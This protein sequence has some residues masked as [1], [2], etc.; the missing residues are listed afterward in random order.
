[1]RRIIT[2]IFVAG[3]IASGISY[4]S[5][6]P[7]ATATTEPAAIVATTQPAPAQPVA[8]GAPICDGSIIDTDCA[9]VEG[10]D[11]GPVIAGGWATAPQARFH[12]V[13]GEVITLYR[14]Q[15][16]VGYG[17]AK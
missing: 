2:L 9:T 7:A 15:Q 11:P 1:M 13:G 4:A 14:Q 6:N 17:C 16:I 8:S 12:C 10:N 3:A 5:S